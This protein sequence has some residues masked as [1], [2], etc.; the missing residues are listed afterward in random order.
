MTLKEFSFL[1]LEP[2][3]YNF[4]FIPT[5]V[6]DTSKTWES[7]TIVYFVATFRED[8]SLKRLFFGYLFWPA[9]LLRRCACFFS[10]AFVIV[11]KC[12]FR[13]FEPFLSSDCKQIG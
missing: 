2:V 12:G 1:V 4:F 8:V 13:L 5:E 11:H 7:L 9:Q 3:L 10:F 6:F